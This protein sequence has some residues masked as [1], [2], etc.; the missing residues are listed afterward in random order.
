MTELKVTVDGK[1]VID[2][3]MG[4]WSENPPEII[5][6][7]LAAN[8]TPKPWM[9]CLLMVVA[10]AAVTATDTTVV[11]AT[12]ETTWTMQVATS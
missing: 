10:N 9:R 7:Q 4:Q 8:A 12:T 6:E 2:G 1:T 5:R 11:I 3:D